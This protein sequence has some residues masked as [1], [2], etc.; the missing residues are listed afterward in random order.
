MPANQ[1]RERP[2]IVLVRE[3]GEQRV[4]PH[5]APGRSEGGEPGR[6]RGTHVDV[7]LTQ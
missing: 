6:T 1:F 3:S 4:V 2:F 7:P 5:L